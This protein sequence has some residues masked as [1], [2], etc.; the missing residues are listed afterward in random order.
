MMYTV[1]V[2]EFSPK[3]LGLTG[4]KEQ[5]EAA[6]KA[7]RVF[8]SVGPKDEDNDYIVSAGAKAT[9]LVYHQY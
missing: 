2:A 1:C 6:T 3:L 5:L 8:F 9:L 7:Y 4:S